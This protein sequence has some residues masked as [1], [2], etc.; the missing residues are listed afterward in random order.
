MI[1]EVVGVAAACIAVVGVAGSSSSVSGSWSGSVSVPGGVRMV[2][3]SVGH[4]G[5]ADDVGAAAPVQR[6][7]FRLAVHGPATYAS[8][9]MDLG[10][11]RSR[12]SCSDWLSSAVTVAQWDES[13]P[14]FRPDSSVNELYW[15][16]ITPTRLSATFGDRATS[17]HDL[18]LVVDFDTYATPKKTKPFD[19][20]YEITWT[21][22]DQ[23]SSSLES[24][25]GDGPFRGR[26]LPI[27]IGLAATVAVVTI[28]ALCYFRKYRSAG[29]PKDIN[30]PPYSPS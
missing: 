4:S 27:T 7:D 16:G 26:T 2:V 19:L 21:Y 6:I 23:G 24:L 14:F 12:L 29:T 15:N 20:D 9:R 28:L 25:T 30:P 8:N 1:V 18:C 3:L 11:H 22:Y 13:P 5:E 17:L 10:M